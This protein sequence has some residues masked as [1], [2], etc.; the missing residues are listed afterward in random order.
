MNFALSRLMVG[1]LN[2]IQEYVLNGYV[3]RNHSNLWHISRWSLPGSFS[4]SHI[5]LVKY[6]ELGHMHISATSIW[7]SDIFRRH[8]RNVDMI[9]MS[10]MSQ[11]RIMWLTE[12]EHICA[13]YQNSNICFK[14]NSNDYAKNKHNVVVKYI[15]LLCCLLCALYFVFL[16]ISLDSALCVHANV[17]VHNWW[18]TSRNTLC[19]TMEMYFLISMFKC[20]NYLTLLPAQWR[21]VFSASIHRYVFIYD[22]SWETKIDPG[23]RHKWAQWDITVT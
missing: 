2:G 12:Y 7:P 16:L 9:I 18:H 8:G 6:L 17:S 3:Y 23:L 13:N 10:V 1:H 19:C 15:C 20:K 22:V 11:F 14:N 21:Y 4:W 5:Y